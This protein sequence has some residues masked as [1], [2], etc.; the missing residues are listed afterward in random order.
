MALDNI[1]VWAP[2]ILQLK[3]L[4]MINVQYEMRI[5]QKSYKKSQRQFM[6]GSNFYGSDVNSGFHVVKLELEI[7]LT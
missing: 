2:S 6:Y 1:I 5:C 4:G 3:D 7:G